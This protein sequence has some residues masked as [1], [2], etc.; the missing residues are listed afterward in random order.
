MRRFVAVLGWGGALLGLAMTGNAVAGDDQ[1][2]AKAAAERGHHPRRR[3]RLRRPGLLRPSDDPHAEPRPHGGRG[4]AFTDFYVAACVCTP[5]RAALLTGRLPIRSGM[6]S[7]T[8]RV[9]SPIHRRIA[10]RGNHDRRARS[11]PRLRDGMRRQ[12][13]SWATCRKFLS[14]DARASTT[15]F[16]IPYT[17]DMKP[18]G[19]PAAMTTKSS[20]SPPI[21]P[22]SPPLHRG[23]DAIHP[24]PTDGR[25]FSV[26]RTPFRTCRC[27]RPTKFRRQER[28][29]PLR[30]RGRGTRLERRARC[31]TRSREWESTKNT[32]V[33]F[34]SDNGPWLSRSRPADRPGC[35]A[36]ARASTWEGGM[37][38]P[39]I[40]WWPG[41]I[42][43]GPRH[44]RTGL[45]DGSV[46]DDLCVGRCRCRGTHARLRSISATCC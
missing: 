37:R 42:P 17:N 36:K 41:T 4:D 6:C 33:F 40:A 23:G 13:A 39:G 32:L 5:S 9:L 46:G 25:S 14:H 44:G 7:D 12:M 8:R 26:R 28:A 20:N 22:R 29:R 31:S 10:A 18:D 43:P 19:A 3:S 16:G 11:K 34:T 24:Q 45:L 38:E 30:R 15:Y 1:G 2:A 21:R 27:S 35:C